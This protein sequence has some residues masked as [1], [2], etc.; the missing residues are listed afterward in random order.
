MVINIG[1][2]RSWFLGTIAAEGWSLAPKIAHKG[3][4]RG[5]FRVCN[6]ALGAVGEG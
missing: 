1:R 4:I 2:K 5:G 6:E 3:I